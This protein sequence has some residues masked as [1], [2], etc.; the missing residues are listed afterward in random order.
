MRASYSSTKASRTTNLN[1]CK[2]LK[3]E[4]DQND[5]NGAANSIDRF[6]KAFWKAHIFWTTDSAFVKTL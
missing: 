5:Q 4:M 2:I 1:L 6:T 3:A